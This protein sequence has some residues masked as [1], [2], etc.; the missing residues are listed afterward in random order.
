MKNTIRLLG[1]IAL[2]TAIAFIAACGNGTTGGGG[3]G[4]GGGGPYT[5]TPK[6]SVYTWSDDDNIYK[7]TVTEILAPSSSMA[8]RAVE[9]GNYTLVITVRATGVQTT[10]TGTAAQA[11]GGGF[12]LSNGGVQITITVDTNIDGTITVKV[13][14]GAKVEGISVTGG[15]G[16]ISGSGGGAKNDNSLIMQANPWLGSNEGWDGGAADLIDL[17]YAKPDQQGMKFRFMIS[18]KSDKALTKAYLSIGQ[19]EP[20]WSVPYNWLGNSELVNLG[21]SFTDRVI[22]VIIE[23]Q[24]DP[25]ISITGVGLCNIAP[26]PAGINEWEPVAEIKDFTIKLLSANIPDEIPLEAASWGSWDTNEKVEAWNY[27]FPLDYLTKVPPRKG[28]TYIFKIS[29]NSDTALRNFDIAIDQFVDLEQWEYA[30]FLGGSFGNG[31]NLGAS[32]QNRVIEVTIGGDWDPKS[33]TIVS[34]RNFASFPAGIKEGD[35][36]ATIKNFQISVEVR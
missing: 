26:I 9:A 15:E 3:G 12:T 2:V 27:G 30:G 4:G 33:V 6:A 11:S 23:G 24:Y 34:I 18:G 32:F 1:I 5:P 36:A 22:E 29:G 28:A 31:A 8:G 25:S 17:T 7:L 19:N 16:T 10:G 35:V 13:S 14:A 21:T 20:D